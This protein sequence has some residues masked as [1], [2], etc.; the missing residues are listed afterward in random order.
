VL[1]FSAGGHLVAA[2][3]NDDRQRSYRA[4]DDADKE[5]CRPDFAVALYPGHL[6]V[7]GSDPPRFN[8]DIHVTRDTPPTFLLQAETDSIDNVNQS[9]VYYAALKDAGVP[10]EMHLYADGGH[11][12]GLRRTK[13]PITEWPPL[14]EKWLR[15]I[16]I[17]SR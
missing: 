10:T 11:A 12:F 7:G 14:V 3:S 15:T 8:P 2:I 9:L 17:L 13:D 4:V 1:G 6:W 5:S 16:G